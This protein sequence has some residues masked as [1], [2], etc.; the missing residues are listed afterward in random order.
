MFEGV[1]Y[2][3]RNHAFGFSSVEHPAKTEEQKWGF[4][5]LA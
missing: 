5:M 1:V 3:G 2:R 4:L